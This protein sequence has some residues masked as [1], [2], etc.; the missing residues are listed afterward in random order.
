MK[1]ILKTK[2]VQMLLPFLIFFS[3]HKMTVTKEIITFQGTKVHL[4]CK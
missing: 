4:L 3:D 1:Q 2:M